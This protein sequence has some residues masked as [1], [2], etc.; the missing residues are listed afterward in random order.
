M[1]STTTT[2]RR[3][4]ILFFVYYFFHWMLT[5]F[6]I[7]S[8]TTTISS[9]F[10]GGLSSEYGV[11]G[12][13]NSSDNGSSSSA[14][15]DGGSISSSGIVQYHLMTFLS[16]RRG[17]NENGNSLG[18]SGRESDDES[19]DHQKHED[20]SYIIGGNDWNRHDKESMGDI[21]MTTRDDDGSSSFDGKNGGGGNKGTANGYFS[22]CLMIKDDNHYLIEWLAYHYHF[23]PL[24]RLIVGI[25]PTSTTSPH[26]ILN[27]YHSR[28]LMN[29]TEWYNPYEDYISKEQ[30]V[31]EQQ[32]KQLQQ[33]EKKRRKKKNL[34]NDRRSDLPP[35]RWS[36]PKSEHPI[37]IFRFQQQTFYQHCLRTLYKESQLHC[38]E[39]H[40]HWVIL[41]DTDEFLVP[42]YY[43]T[44]K[45]HRIKKKLGTVYDML[46]HPKN[47]HFNYHHESPCFPLHRQQI[48]AKE[49]SESGVVEVVDPTMSI[50]PYN[51]N[52]SNFMTYKYIWPTL[53]ELL[54]GKAM[55][56]LSHLSP[57]STTPSRQGHVSTDA[58]TGGGGSTNG[59]RNNNSNDDG[60]NSTVHSSTADGE[61]FFRFGNHN[62]HRPIKDLCKTAQRFK[63]RSPFVVNHYSGSLE[64]YQY[65]HD[66]RSLEERAETENEKSAASNTTNASNSS[67]ISSRSIQSF[68][69]KALTNISSVP[70]T[71]ATFWIHDFIY[72]TTK[73]HNVEGV[74][75]KIASELL[76]GVGSIT[77]TTDSDN[78]KNC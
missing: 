1:I 58:G 44:S 40:D 76:K 73:N 72:G 17:E 47:Q 48:S 46:Q 7:H 51:Y 60:T 54:P 70:D 77:M 10:H 20:E 38:H 9:D 53:R 14:G 32:Y 69:N 49:V 29:I 61:H 27:R 30:I 2:T 36:Y 66:V 4:G 21:N 23:L 55:I 56:N 34:T 25:D 24:R 59:S 18:R 6:H 22:A 67:N 3:G 64:Q 37:D 13:T 42:N 74:G 39:Q 65:R 16:H 43:D 63:Y 75:P 52:L 26:C 31:L 41:L 28:G 78:W 50:Q 68:I 15:G 35:I 11:N 45:H 5:L 71:S 8:T 33:D 57:S 19:M 62:P 12:G